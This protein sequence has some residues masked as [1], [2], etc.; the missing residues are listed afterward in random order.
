MKKSFLE[1]EVD[2]QEWKILKKSYQFKA[3]K[4]GDGTRE[5]CIDLSKS[6]NDVRF[7]SWPF[8]TTEFF[9]FIKSNCKV[10]CILFYFDFLW[11]IDLNGNI[12]CTWFY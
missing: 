2:L 3:S 9:L 7:F 5:A 6:Y 10:F 4:G 1:R 8:E 12:L 11:V